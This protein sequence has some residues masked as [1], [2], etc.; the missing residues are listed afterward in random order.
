MRMYHAAEQTPVCELD[1]VWVEAMVSFAR[2]GDGEVESYDMVI[3]GGGGVVARRGSLWR[4][5]E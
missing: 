1:Y 3:V 5:I 2:Q 4:S